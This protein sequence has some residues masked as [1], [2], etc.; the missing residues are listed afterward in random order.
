MDDS[1]ELV[2]FLPDTLQV[3]DYIP[4]IEING[5]GRKKH[6]HNYCNN[7]PFIFV[8]MKIFNG[9]F[10]HLFLHLSEQ[11]NV[12]VLFNE[13]EAKCIDKN[14]LYTKC[15]QLKKIL[16]ICEEPRVYITSPNRRILSIINDNAM[17]KLYMIK[18]DDYIPN[19]I[20]IPYLVIE[21]ALDNKLLNKVK[22]FYNKKKAEG[23]LQAHRHTT[24]SRLHVHPDGELEKELDHKLSRCILPE[25]KKVFYF[26]TEYRETYKICS[27]DAES[28]GRFHPH[29]DTPHP[30]Q[31]R[32]YALSLFLNDDYEGGEFVLSEYGLKIKPKANTAFIF[33]GINTHQVL[34]V[35][36]GSRMT[37]ITFFV[38]G[39]TKPQYKMKAHYYKEKQISESLVYPL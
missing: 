11:F 28:S 17:E 35:T 34:P 31:H 18:K 19:N 2:N 10:F 15:M 14:V 27:Y 26:D 25:L 9:D 22:E 21:D 1:E 29:R 39:E 5:E 20:H 13:G 24:K 30:Y 33:P 12:V 38:N 7:D 4:F 32:K 16:S 8:T 23:K 37:I 3:G 6:I 36:K